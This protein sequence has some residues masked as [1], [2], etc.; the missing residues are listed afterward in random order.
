MIHTFESDKKNQYLRQSQPRG[1]PHKISGLGNP[2]SWGSKKC[3]VNSFSSNRIVLI[4]KHYN[5]DYIWFRFCN[6]I[7]VKSAKCDLNLIFFTCIYV[8]FFFILYDLVI[9]SKKCQS[10]LESDLNNPNVEAELPMGR[11]RVVLLVR[12]LR[13][14][15]NS[16]ILSCFIFIFV[17]VVRQPCSIGPLVWVSKEMSSRTESLLPEPTPSPTRS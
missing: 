16:Y 14:K 6:V 7:Q 1:K 13:R 11:R 5:W 10:N 4:I 3:K 9:N 12:V 15:L 8:C 2:P 17:T